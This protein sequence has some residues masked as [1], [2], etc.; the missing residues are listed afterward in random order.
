MV[1]S[2]ISNKGQIKLLGKALLLVLLLAVIYFSIIRPLQA[3][4]ESL[5]G[6]QIQGGS[7]FATACPDEYIKMG[8]ATCGDLPKKY[9]CCKPVSGTHNCKSLG[10]TCVK[11]EECKRPKQAVVWTKTDC[12]DN[13]EVCCHNQCLD[14]PTYTYKKFDSFHKSGGGTLFN[15]VKPSKCE[16]SD[17][18][19]VNAKYNFSFCSDKDLVCCD[20]TKR[21]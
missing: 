21:G 4:A 15:C 2:I 11:K 5:G 20:Y 8:T 16:D 10:G 18:Y 3:N 14:N 1:G 13:N 19:K 6:C 7:C 12:N 17:K 9:V